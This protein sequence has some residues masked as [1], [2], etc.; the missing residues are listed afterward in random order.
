MKVKSESEVAQQPHGLQL[1]GP[2]TYPK[3][4]ELSYFLTI[5]KVLLCMLNL[6]LVIQH[7]KY[8]LQELFV[9]QAPITLFES[10]YR[11]LH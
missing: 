3:M 7:A 1:L 6:Y 2:W 11:H 5:C 4:L 10:K 9:H 8:F